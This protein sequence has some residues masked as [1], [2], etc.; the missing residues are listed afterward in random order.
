MRV[1]SNLMVSGM[2]TLH[3]IAKFLT[4]NLCAEQNA[5]RRYPALLL[6]F[7]CQLHAAVASTPLQ[8]EATI[9]EEQGEGATSRV[10]ASP[11]S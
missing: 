6:L 5:G 10:S 11:D 1:K 7:A 8:L 2:T 9:E 3:I 4:K